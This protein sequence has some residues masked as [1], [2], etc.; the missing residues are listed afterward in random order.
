MSLLLSHW[1]AKFLLLA[2]FSAPP[3]AE[4]TNAQLAAALTEVSGVPVSAKEVWTFSHHQIYRWQDAPVWLHK[5]LGTKYKKLAYGRFHKKV[6]TIRWAVFEMPKKYRAKLNVDLVL[7]EFTDEPE[8]AIPPNFQPC[9]AKFCDFV[10]GGCVTQTWLT[11]GPCMNEC[12]SA[13]DCPS[14][15]QCQKLMC[16]GSHC[17]L[18]IYLAGECDNTPLCNSDADCGG[19]ENEKWCTYKECQNSSCVTVT[20]K[21]GANEPCPV[22]RCQ[23][24]Q[25]CNLLGGLDTDGIIISM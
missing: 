10:N 20:V 15:E 7:L 6:K 11:D 9:T 1:Q 19:E 18:N 21:V 2:A 24:D 5:N 8:P 25:N 4:L 3:S 22:D 13:S 17:V 12:N 16:V 23:N 14:V